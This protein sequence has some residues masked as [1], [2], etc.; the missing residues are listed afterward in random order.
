VDNRF[1]LLPVQVHLNARQVKRSEQSLHVVFQP[2]EAAVSAAKKIKNTISPLEQKI[3]NMKMY[4]LEMDQVTI[5][6]AII[7]LIHILKFN[8]FFAALE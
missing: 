5:E 3:R 6:V 8:Y 2:G 1:K 4:V 7:R